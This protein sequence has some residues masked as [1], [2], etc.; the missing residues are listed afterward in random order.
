MYQVEEITTKFL[1]KN[2][3]LEYGI[4]VNIEINS[5]PELL[6]TVHKNNI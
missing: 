2:K 5:D 4:E 3:K 6:V 1:K